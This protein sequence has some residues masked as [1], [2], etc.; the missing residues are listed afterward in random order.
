M[1]DF[2]APSLMTVGNTLGGDA[3]C[4]NGFK[5]DSCSV[6]NLVDYVMDGTSKT[7]GCKSEL[8]KMSLV[9]FTR[10]RRRHRKDPI[11]NE[12]DNYLEGLVLTSTFESNAYLYGFALNY[13]SIVGFKDPAFDDPADNDHYNDDPMSRYAR[14]QGRKCPLDWQAVFTDTPGGEVVTLATAVSEIQGWIR[15]MHPHNKMR[16]PKVTKDGNSESA[17]TPPTISFRSYKHYL[18]KSAAAF[19]TCD[20]M[21]VP[22]YFT[23]ITT[24]TNATPWHIA[25]EIW[26]LFSAC[27]AFFW[28]TVIK[29]IVSVTENK[30]LSC[31][32]FMDRV[33]ALHAILPVVLQV[34]GSICLGWT[35]N[36]QLWLQD[37]ESKSDTSIDPSAKNEGIVIFASTIWIM[38]ALLL[39]ILYGLIYRIIRKLLEWKTSHKA[40]VPD[41][42][43]IYMFLHQLIFGAQ[44]AMDVPV[45]VGLTFIAVGTVIQRG[46]GDY[47]LLLTVVVLF[48]L[49]SIT[50]HIT[51]AL[52]LMHLIA[53]SDIEKDDH[54]QKIKYN[55]V[56]IGV[57]IVVLLY[58]YLQLAGLDS[59]QGGSYGEV[60][61]TIFAFVAFFVLCGGNL[62]LEFLCLFQADDNQ[63]TDPH[64]NLYHLIYRK[65]RNTNTVWIIIYRIFVLNLHLYLELCQR[66]N[67]IEGR[68]DVCTWGLTKA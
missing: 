39:V 23:R 1:R 34:F 51:N 32:N 53:Q 58:V 10:D 43:G 3:N 64:D 21:G 27:F 28:A 68:A 52:R 63:Y 61:Q 50:T 59:Y 47:Y 15:M 18:L 29:N 44:I 12:F 7:N 54:A 48:L 57:L 42:N 25:G 19:E 2:A 16:S 60:H 46:V 41:P 31:Y 8:T 9:E 24:Y 65:T 17:S 13:C 11:I 4:V 56:L 62:T 22:Q 45:I 37:P 5:Q 20:Q 49:I 33:V 40:T 14:E 66:S 36:Q 26:L 6:Q 67:P 38:Y 55:R 35:I 30:P